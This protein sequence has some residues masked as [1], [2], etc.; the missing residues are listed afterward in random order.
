MK[1]QLDDRTIRVMIT[2]AVV[3]SGAVTPPR[4]R[5]RPDQ[6]LSPDDSYAIEVRR[7]ADAAMEVALADLD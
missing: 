6:G 7:L 3:A 2:A 4:D 1:N 5:P